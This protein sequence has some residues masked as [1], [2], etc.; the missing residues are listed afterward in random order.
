MRPKQWAKNLF[1]FA[2]LV[3]DQKLT[4]PTALRNTFFGFV[5]FCL[6][7]SAV[8]LIN[9]LADVEADRQHPTKRNR[10]IAAGELSVLT[11]RIAAV[12]FIAI[13]L[14]AALLFFPLFAALALGYL[15]LNLAYTFRLKHVALL[16]VLVL[17]SFYVM[18]VGAGVLLVDVER[19]SPWIY[20]STIFLALLIGLGKRRAEL[21]LLE[22]T[23]NTHRKVLD[24]Y[25]IPFLDELIVIVSAATIMTYS[26]YTFS[27]PNVP[28]NH[29]M[30]L[31]IPFVIYGIFRYMYL[32]K[33]KEIGGAPE[34]IAYSDRPIQA[35]IVLWGLAVI[36][37]FY[38]FRP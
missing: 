7:S 19:F 24:G 16:D 6:L 32:L 3:F 11:A 30:M 1:I 22:G 29:T 15:V 31:T 25:T 34:E 8:Y 13:S 12:A 28:D 14:T 10:P 23:A 33:V 37:I 17:A 20:A 4:D 2:P 27:A 9:D 36:L 38:I 18:R 5:V 35:T 26:L 21:T